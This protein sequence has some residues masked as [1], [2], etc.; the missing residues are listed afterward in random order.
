MRIF[1]ANAKNLKILFRKS[2]H[3]LH[4]FEAMKIL[5]F[6]SQNNFVFANLKQNPSR[7]TGCVKTLAP[8]GLFEGFFSGGTKILS[9]GTWKALPEWGTQSFLKNKIG[10]KSLKT[11]YFLAKFHFEAKFP[12]WAGVYILHAKS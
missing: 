8:Q 12:N 1:L 6:P 9:G 2:K 3:N 10:L 7:S 4:N 11:S 5:L